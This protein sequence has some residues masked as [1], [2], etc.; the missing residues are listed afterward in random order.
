MLR[1]WAACA[2]LAASADPTPPPLTVVS[3]ANGRY[4]LKELA[5]LLDIKDR[6]KREG[7]GVRLISYDLGD[8]GQCQE[9]GVRDAAP[10]SLWSKF[11]IEYRHFDFRK[12]PGHVAGLHCYAWK[13]PIIAEVAEEVGNASVVMWIDSGATVAQPLRNVVDKTRS[14]GGYVSDETAK[15]LARFLHEKV[16]DYFVAHY[17]LAAPLAREIAEKR[18]RGTNLDDH[19]DFSDGLKRF[20]NCNGAFSAHVYGSPKYASVTRKWLECSLVKDCTCPPG[21]TRANHRQDQAALTLFSLMDDYVCG[22][23]GKFVAAHG[24]RNSQLILEHHGV[25]SAKQLTEHQI[26]CHANTTVASP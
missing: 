21:S 20:R 6:A 3:A 12:Y 19:D 9:E 8:S 11:G 5:V 15:G 26:W 14:N 16:L 10:S 18:K 17:G 22:A 2:A 4:A 1:V 24:L 13:A 23:H 25:H 7:L